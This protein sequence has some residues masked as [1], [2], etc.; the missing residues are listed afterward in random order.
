VTR[1]GRL[2]RLG[3]LAAASAGAGCSGGGASG[4]KPFDAMSA[5]EHLACAVDI[6][7]VTYLMAAGKV[8]EESELAGKS[9]LAVAWHHNAYAIPQGKGGQYERVNRMR[10]ELMAK[11]QPDAIAARAADCIT[12]AVAKHEAK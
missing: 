7:A 3:L 10:E 11:D 9:V 8:P 5:E 4:P 6:S 12:S 1:A 2:A